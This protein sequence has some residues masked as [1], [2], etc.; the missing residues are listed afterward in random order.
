MMQL[1]KTKKPVAT[2]LGMAVL[3]GLL[4]LGGCSDPVKPS[5][6]GSG[7]KR[8]DPELQKAKDSMDAYKAKALQKPKANAK[9]T[10]RPG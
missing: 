1:E 6:Y 5:A 3:A 9:A 8:G 7:D 10:R 4:S 2:I